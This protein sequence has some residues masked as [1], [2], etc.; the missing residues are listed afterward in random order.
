[1]KIKK[2]W[3]TKAAMTQIYE[4]YLWGKNDQKYFSGEG[5]HHPKIV[6][7][8]CEAV[9]SFLTS[10]KEPLRVCDLG[11]GDFNIGNQLVPFTKEYIAVDIVDELIAFNKMK[12]QQQNL[13]FLSLDIANDK[14]PNADCVIVRQVLQHLSNKEV[15]Q[16]VDK[17]YDYKY[18]IVTEHLPNIKFE[19]NK[20]IISGQGIRL[21]KQSGLDI[22][23]SP[24][25]FKAKE[26]RTI[27]STVLENNKGKIETTLF[28]NS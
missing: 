25:N 21:K 20:D 27:C 4:Q 15:K 26:I 5:S 7:P 18:V 3:P 6:K 17:L 28:T 14:L 16:V 10:F 23:K 22:T 12:F 11:C 13:Q 19:P 8:Y 9:I 1:M 24:F 2:P